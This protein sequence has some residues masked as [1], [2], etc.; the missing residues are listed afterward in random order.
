MKLEE[1]KARLDKMEN[2][3]QAESWY[4]KSLHLLKARS[5]KLRDRRERDVAACKSKNKELQNKLH[6]LT[7]SKM[8][9]IKA[10]DESVLHLKEFEHLC[11]RHENFRNENLVALGKLK[12]GESSAYIFYLMHAHLTLDAMHSH[13]PS[14]RR[15]QPCNG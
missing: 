3:A 10:R 8:E 4:S 5:Q 7:R 11:A 14:H 12:L 1:T 2:D 9:L 13:F 15:L 6:R